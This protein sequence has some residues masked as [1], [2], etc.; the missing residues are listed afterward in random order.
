MRR[1]PGT[2][3]AE[4]TSQGTTSCV[5][6]SFACRLSS[7]LFLVSHRSVL[8]NIG[9]FLPRSLLSF[10]LLYFTLLVPFSAFLKSFFFPFPFFFPL[11]SLLTFPVHLLSLH[12]HPS[13]FLSCP[14][15]IP[16]QSPLTS[17]FLTSPLFLMYFPSLLFL[18]L[19][20]PVSP[21]PS[22][23]FVPAVSQLVSACLRLK[24]TAE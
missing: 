18:L 16:P 24:T 13:T 2:Y 21:S 14:A 11:F 1:P 5:L 3:V 8:I 12:I 9:P 17:P 10:F 23:P 19:F 20:P 7:F 22:L 15:H 6:S 4:R